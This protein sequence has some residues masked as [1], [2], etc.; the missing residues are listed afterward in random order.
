MP[1]IIAGDFNE[2]P[3]NLP[4]SNVMEAHFVDLHA[5]MKIQNLKFSKDMRENYPILSTIKTNEAGEMINKLQDY[6]FIAENDYYKQHVPT[7]EEFLDPKD[8]ITNKLKDLKGI[9]NQTH[10]SDH[11]SLAYKVKFSFSKK[12]E[13]NEK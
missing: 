5:L 9:P 13:S 7:I 4:I 8:I 2:E 10:P 6:I 11:I 12:D 3:E 1:V